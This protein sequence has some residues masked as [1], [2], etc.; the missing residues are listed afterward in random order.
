MAAVIR[1][2]RVEGNTTTLDIG[3]GTRITILGQTGNI[4]AWFN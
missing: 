3:G 1:S 2:A 4:A